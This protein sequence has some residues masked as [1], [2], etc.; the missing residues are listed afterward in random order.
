MAEKTLA[1]EAGAKN[2]YETPVLTAV[3]S[4]EALTQWAGTGWALDAP[5]SAGTPANTLTFSDPPR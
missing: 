1:G 4:F 5:F 3:G 2:T